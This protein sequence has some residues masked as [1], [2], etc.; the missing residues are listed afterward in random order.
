MKGFFQA[1]QTATAPYVQ[2]GRFKTF[3]GESA[4]VPGLTPGNE[5]GHTPGHC[6]YLFESKGQKLLVWGDVVHNVAVQFPQPTVT[7][8]FDS[9]QPKA[10]AARLKLL[11]WAAKEPSLLV[12]AAHLPFPGLGHVRAEGK[13]NGYAWVPVDFAPVA[14]LPV[15]PAVAAKPAP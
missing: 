8:D 10:L 13:G 12:A 6:G 15:P 1:A 4:L 7:I 2:T 5:H 9:D 14:P 3:E 11:A